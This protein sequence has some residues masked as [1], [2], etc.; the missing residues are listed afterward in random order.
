LAEVVTVRGWHG[1][2]F[3]FYF[4]QDYVPSISSTAI[5]LNESHAHFT[6]YANCSIVANLKQ[7][8]PKE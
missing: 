8:R 1:D 2:N 6:P 7:S 4:F 5:P 3:Y